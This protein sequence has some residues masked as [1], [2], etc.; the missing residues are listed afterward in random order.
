MRRE[1]DE[2]EKK[3]ND[4]KEIIGYQQSLEEKENKKLKLDEKSKIIEENK[5]KV[6]RSGHAKIINPHIK[7]VQDF[8]KSISQ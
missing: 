4:Y 6:E 1:L 7:N 8:E 3:Y 5:E 2:A